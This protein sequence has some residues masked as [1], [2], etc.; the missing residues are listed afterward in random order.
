MIHD[1]K[2]DKFLVTGF[3][4]K[5]SELGSPR[6]GFF[7]EAPFDVR[8]EMGLLLVGFED[9]PFFTSPFFTC[10]LKN[11]I[12]CNLCNKAPPP[13]ELFF[14]IFMRFQLP[15]S[16][17]LNVTSVRPSKS[18]LKLHILSSP[19]LL[20]PITCFIS[21]TLN[22]LFTLFILCLFPPECMLYKDENFFQLFC[23]LLYF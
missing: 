10:P 3:E 19:M 8:L 9:S 12:N 15:M 23:S 1:L 22:N 11:Q 16:F 2:Q 21:I 7:E 17:C 5:G 4:G 13:P 18:Y 14:Q 20:F 6:E